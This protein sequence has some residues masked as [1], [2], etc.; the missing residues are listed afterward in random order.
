MGKRKQTKPEPAPDPD[1]RRRALMRRVSAENPSGED[2]AALAALMRSEPERWRNTGNMI[3]LA[4]QLF[5][6]SFQTSEMEKEILRYKCERMKA[7]LGEETDGAMERAMID[8]VVLC[9]LRL[10][11][12]QQQY[13]RVTSDGITLTMGLFWEKRLSSAQKRF[14]DACVSLARVRKLNR[15]KVRNL[16]N[17]GEEKLDMTAGIRKAT[18]R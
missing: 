16:V 2:V 5:I 10:G 11:V 17:I 18:G 3:E 12:M 6:D 4:A 14:D 13:S 1:A 7:D 15:P 8:H 9:W